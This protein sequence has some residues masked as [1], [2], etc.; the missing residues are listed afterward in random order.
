MFSL[1][2]AESGLLARE[3]S[4][5]GKP[6][7]PGDPATATAYTLG[8]R[9]RAR[10]ERVMT[11]FALPPDGVRAFLHDLK[12]NLP[13]AWVVLEHYRLFSAGFDEQTALTFG[14]VTPPRAGASGVVQAPHL[15]YLLPPND[16]P[17][18]QL[19]NGQFTYRLE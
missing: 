16:V 5:L 3:P 10:L 7:N 9:W 14:G 8:Q 4:D 19:L 11:R 18:G 12:V 13:G 2:A 1:V 17:F 6:G 15:T